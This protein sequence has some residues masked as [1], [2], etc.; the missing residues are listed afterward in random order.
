MSVPTPLAPPQRWPVPAT[1]FSQQPYRAAYFAYWIASLPFLVLLWVLQWSLHLH[2]HSFLF[3]LSE[4]LYARGIHRGMT[5]AARAAFFPDLVRL[6][7]RPGE[8]SPDALNEASRFERT[9]VQWVPPPAEAG[10]WFAGHA[11][12]EGCEPERIGAVV[13]GKP[14]RG[15]PREDLAVGPNETVFLHLHGGGLVMGNATEK[16]FINQFAAEIIECDAVDHVLSPEYRQLDQGPWPLPL[17]DCITAYA[18]LVDTLK[19]APSRI[20]VGGD[21]A[22]GLLAL[23]L[24]RYLRDDLQ[25]ELPRAALLVSPLANVSR[26]LG[27][28][29]QLQPSPSRHIDLLN[30][31]A[32][33]CLLPSDL[34]PLVL[35]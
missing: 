14:G 1:A 10:K 27:P 6:G 15:P 22:G 26:W 18:Y 19:V 23:A 11:V 12:K 32:V 21:S 35:H 29:L 31:E 16:Y 28:K 4:S 8:L 5:L 17:V 2:P 30:I 20:L 13:W 33:S 3:S 34:Y 7:D 24:L 9:R 25:A